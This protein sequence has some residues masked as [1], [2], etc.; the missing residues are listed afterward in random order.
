MWNSQTFFG[1][2]L[3][4]HHARKSKPDKPT[5]CKTSRSDWDV[6]PLLSHTKDSEHRQHS[7]LV[8]AEGMGHP[9]RFPSFAKIERILLG[10][11]FWQVSVAFPSI[12]FVQEDLRSRARFWTLQFS[13]VC[14]TLKST[15]K[16]RPSRNIFFHSQQLKPWAIVIQ[17]LAVSFARWAHQITSLPSFQDKR[18]PPKSITWSCPKVLPS[19]NPC[20]TTPLA[21]FCNNKTKENK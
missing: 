4:H 3:C 12:C 5:S 20:R 8:S 15:L 13:K 7:L 11:H 14:M 19:S 9:V 17:S 21:L 16:K 6:H 1:H 18:T 10:Q 2:L